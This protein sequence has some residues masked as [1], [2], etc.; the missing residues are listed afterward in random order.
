V[1]EYE[2]ADRDVERMRAAARYWVEQTTN[3]NS[4]SLDG[5]RCLTTHDH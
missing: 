2:T 5:G 4:V 3:L 1:S